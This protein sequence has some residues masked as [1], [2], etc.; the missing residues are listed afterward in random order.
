MRTDPYSSS[1]GINQR[2]FYKQLITKADSLYDA[3][4]PAMKSERNNG[5]AKTFDTLVKQTT[6]QQ[7]RGRAAARTKEL[8]VQMLIGQL[9]QVAGKSQREVAGLLGIRHPR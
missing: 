7:T 4:L 9:Q 3:Y 8:L 5:M 1:P 2:R 6:T